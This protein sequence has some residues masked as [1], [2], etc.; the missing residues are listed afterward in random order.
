MIKAG[1]RIQ[2]GK[3]SN[4]VTRMLGLWRPLTL[5]AYILKFENKYGGI[6]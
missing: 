6:E 3:D 4:A 5:S 1:A 2:A